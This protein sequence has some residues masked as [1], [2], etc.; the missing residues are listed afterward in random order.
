MIYTDIILKHL[1]FFLIGIFQDVFIT[2]Y[3]QTIA[4]ERAWRAAFFSTAVTLINIVILY[5]ILTGIE[6][7]VISVILAYAVGN[8]VGTLIVMKKHRLKRL[9]AKKTGL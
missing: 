9:F 4:K 3:Y 2:Y 8:G 7:Q 5:K 1:A 6:D